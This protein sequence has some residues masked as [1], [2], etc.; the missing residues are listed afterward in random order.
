MWKWI[1]LV[2][3]KSFSTLSQRGW[4]DA[5][6][7]RNSLV[8]RGP[9]FLQLQKRVEI[10]PGSAFSLSA[11][12]EENDFGGGEEQTHLFYI[13]SDLGI[14]HSRS[15]E[16][17]A[18]SKI[19]EFF[20]LQIP[21]SLRSHPSYFPMASFAKGGWQFTAVSKQIFLLPGCWQ[22]RNMTGSCPQGTLR[23]PQ[24]V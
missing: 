11:V 22:Q 20:C 21:G 15:L 24:Q 8:C 2:K 10:L 19:M 3:I 1:V 4:L 9:P 7:W 6:E 16:R 13:L 5:Q 18:R 23:G 14:F 17:G 12:W